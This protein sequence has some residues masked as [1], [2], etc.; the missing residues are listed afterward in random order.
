MARPHPH[1]RAARLAAISILSVLGAVVGVWAA[2]RVSDAVAAWMSAPPVELRSTA[3][4]AALA[5]RSGVRSARRARPPAAADGRRRDHRRRHALHHGRRHL[6]PPPR[7][8][9]GRRAAAHQRGRA[10]LEPLVRRR[11]RA[12]RGRGRRGEG[13]HRAHLDRR[14]PL[15]A[16]ERAGRPGAPRPAPAR[17]RDVTRRGHQQHGGRR[18]RV[19]GRRRAPPRR[20]HRRRLPI[21]TPHG[22]GHDDQ[23][24]DRDP[25]GVG[26]QRIL[27]LRVARL[28]ARQDGLRAPHRQRQRLLRARRRPRSCAASMPTTPSRCTGATSATTS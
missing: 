17:L 16:G 21:S 4:P 28:R 19:R 1:K 22:R 10:D 23:A 11:A 5:G 18:P 8:R 20:R 15:P 9:R 14:R 24:A 27:A 2:P 25:V 6:S 26:R 12:R 13:L 7:G 3:L